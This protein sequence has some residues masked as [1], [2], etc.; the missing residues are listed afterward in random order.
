MQTTFSNHDSTKKE[1]SYNSSR[2]I[3]THKHL[4]A[5]IWHSVFWVTASH[6]MREEK[7]AQFLS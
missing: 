1:T 3:D 2:G 5:E 4:E 7:I 6:F